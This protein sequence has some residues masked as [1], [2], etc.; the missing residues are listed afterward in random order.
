MNR[1]EV[2]K[3]EILR[4]KQQAA[5]KDAQER[6]TRQE[7]EQQRLANEQA[8]RERL[9][10]IEEN[11]PLVRQRVIQTFRAINE[12]VIGQQGKVI[13]WRTIRTNHEHYYLKGDHGMTPSGT[14]GCPTEYRYETSSE[15][16][17]LIIEDVGKVVALREISGKFKEK[18]EKPKT[19]KGP[20]DY[21]DI[22][23]CRPEEVLCSHCKGFSN[24]TQ[25]NLGGQ[26]EGVF[27]RVD[28]RIIESVR[29]LLT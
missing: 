2:L 24:L 8:D 20:F 9:R 23:S 12:E 15:V 10:E 5:E 3:Q 21:F 7:N 11:W 17:E 16:A 29:S 28:S 6:R 22:K 25:V 19:N 1:L 14:S 13:P 26:N 18:G 4:I 27:D